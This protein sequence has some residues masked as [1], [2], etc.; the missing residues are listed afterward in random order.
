MLF[1]SIELSSSKVTADEV[2]TI[3]AMVKNT[4]KVAGAEVV[5]LYLHDVESSV[6]RPA[7][8]LKGFAKVMLAPGE[9]KQV[10]ISLNKRDLSFW[11][12][13]SNDWLAESGEFEVQLGTSLD[14]IKLKKRFNY[15]Q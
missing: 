10:S 4:G 1:R 14:K 11:D 8:E 12:V 3:T 7:K 6:E 5:Q 9:S 15:Q 2:I 13:N